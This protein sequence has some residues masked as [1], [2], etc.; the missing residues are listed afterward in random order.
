VQ[1]PCTRVVGQEANDSITLASQ[2]SSIT[3]GW[4]IKVE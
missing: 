2:H 3:T 4:A 1:E